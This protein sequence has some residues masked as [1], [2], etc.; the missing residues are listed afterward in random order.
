MCS[1]LAPV[2]APEMRRRIKKEVEVPIIPTVLYAPAQP[3]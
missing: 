3:C 2:A 1:T